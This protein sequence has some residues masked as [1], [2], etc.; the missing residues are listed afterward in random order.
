MAIIAM[1]TMSLL[2]FVINFIE[3]SFVAP[4]TPMQVDINAVESSIKI[5]QNEQLKYKRRLER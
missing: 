3:T 1:M 4:P 2:G 5:A